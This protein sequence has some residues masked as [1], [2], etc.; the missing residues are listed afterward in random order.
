MGWLENI[1]YTIILIMMVIIGIT[2]A[3]GV[4]KIGHALTTHQI[5]KMEETR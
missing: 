5:N 2:Y 3:K 4:N 1:L